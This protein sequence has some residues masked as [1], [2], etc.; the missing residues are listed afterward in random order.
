MTRAVQFDICEDLEGLRDTSCIETYLQYLFF[1]VYNLCD[2]LQFLAPDAPVQEP[3]PN[4]ILK[5]NWSY[6]ILHVF[7]LGHRDRSML[8]ALAHPQRS[9]DIRFKLSES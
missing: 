5:L 6:V 4:S 9:L 7:S 1:L 3:S 8:A 2:L